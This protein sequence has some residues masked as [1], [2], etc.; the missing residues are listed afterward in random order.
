MSDQ[1]LRLPQVIGRVKLSRSTLYNLV[2]Q[3]AFPAPVRIGVRARGWLDDEIT[4]FLARRAAE[5]MP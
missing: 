4:A 3:G 2:R 5:R 1:I